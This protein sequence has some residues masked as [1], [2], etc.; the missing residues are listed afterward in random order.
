MS[1]PPGKPGGLI[2]T[3]DRQEYM[4]FERERKK[5]I[6]HKLATLNTGLAPKENKNG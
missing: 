2:I 5:I 6:D 3:M 4:G 1:I